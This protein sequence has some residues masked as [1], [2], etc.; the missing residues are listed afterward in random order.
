MCMYLNTTVYFIIITIIIDVLYYMLMYISA[1]NKY[2]LSSWKRDDVALS[3]CYI[4]YG[5]VRRRD[6]RHLCEF[7]KQQFCVEQLIY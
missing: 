2:C 4:I 1:E 7:Q 3:P 6:C 5:Y